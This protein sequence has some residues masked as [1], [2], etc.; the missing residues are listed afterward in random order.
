MISSVIRA[1]KNIVLITAGALFAI[2]IGYGISAQTQLF[3]D[4]FQ[5][6]ND[7]GWTRSSGT[8]SIVTDGSLAYR[9]SGTSADSNARAGSPSW[10]N[11]SIQARVKPIAFNGADRYV[12][13][14]ARVVNSNHYYFLALQNG[15]RLLLGKRAGSSPITLATKSFTFSTGTFYTLRIDVN[16]SSLTGFVNGTQQLTASDSEFTAGIIGGAT[17]FASASFDDFLVTSIGGGG[18]P[19]PAPTGLVATPGN[20]QVSLSWNAST[21]ATSYNVKR[22]TTSGGPYTTIATGVTAT[23]FTNT[24]LVNGTTYFFVVTAVNSAGESGNSNQA[25][26]TPLGTPPPAPTGLTAT[27]GNAQVTLNWNASSGASSYNVKRSTTNG[28]PYTTIATGVTSTSFTN[29]GLTNGTTFFFVVSAVN[30]AGESGNSN[31]ASA[32]PQLSV[33]PAPTNLVATP[34]DGQVSLSWNA[35]SGA[36]SYNVKRSTTSGGPYS[37]VASGVTST[38]FTNTGLTNGTTYFFVVSAV[39][40]AGESGNSNQASATPQQSSAGDIIVAPN[41]TDSNPG[42][43]NAPTTLTAAITRIQ[44]GQTIQMRG[45]T[46]NFSATITI[47]RGNNGT[48]SQPKNIFAF[49]GERPILDF[50]AQSFSSSN[51]GLQLNGFF[52]RLR[53]LEVTGA[54]DNGIFIGG[55]NNT[56]ERCVTHHNRDSGLQLS[57]HSSSAP[58]SEW[59]ANNLILNCDSFDNFDPD[60]GEDADGFACKLTTG[61]GNVF[62]G[63]IAHNNIDDG[64]DLFTKTDTGPISPVTIENCISYNNGRLSTGSTTTASDGNGFKLG[65]DGIPVN[66]TIRRSIAFGN[67]KHGITFNSNPGSITVTNNTS[68]NNGQ[69]NIKFDT[70]THVFTNNLSF[71]GTNSDH[72]TGTDVS[73]TNCWWKNGVSVNAKGLVVSAADF[74][75]LTPTVT[76]NADGSINLGN[77]LRLAPGSDLINAG[78]PSGTDIGAIESQ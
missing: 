48:A 74:V 40:S 73:S 71:Q 10:T 76:R 77:F 72:T 17:F 55:N 59:P 69:E 57:R 64:W 44:P 52:W 9:Q 27:P 1:R 29:T 51:R 45:G 8:W 56:I 41:G 14:M 66:H 67:K 60:N 75:S 32:T 5:D 4:D 15:N 53:G 2:L 26:A 21:G 50:S 38:S 68:L 23:N 30:S 31:Q 42:T 46:Y 43:I 3:S 54:G 13:V 34:G 20:A 18:S 65:G 7:N 28:G 47:A 11:I 58:Q 35:S 16:G 70:G 33:P 63:C 12:G 19:P 22:S 36:T 62:R 78:T 37:T 6:G 24:Q 25:S 49:N 39:N 61:P